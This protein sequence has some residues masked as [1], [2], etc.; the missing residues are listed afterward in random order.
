MK[1][2]KMYDGITYIRED[3]VEEA[4][5][6]KFKKKSTKSAWMK[7]GTMA[8]CACLIVG[9]G[10]QILFDNRGANSGGGGNE[11]GTIFMSYAG[12]VFPLNALNDATGIVAERNID[13]D[14]SPY[15]S[16]MASHEIYGE[17]TGY[18]YYNTESIV[19]DSYTLSNTSNGDIVLTA[20]YPFVGNFSSGYKYIP[21]ISVNGIEVETEL[22][23]GRF[24][25]SFYSASGP[26]SDKTDR[27]N[28]AS[29]EAWT[30]FQTLL[31]DGRYLEDA[32]A[33]YPELNQ[34]VIVYKLSNIA[35]NGTD[36]KATNPT[37]CLE[38]NATYPD[39]LILSYGSTGGRRDREAGE[40]QQSY[41]IPEEN[42]RNYGMDRYLI[43]L[44]ED[45]T[46]LEVKGYR[47]GG[48]DEG[49]DIEGVTADL[50]R[51]ETTLGEIVWEL[52][53]EGREPSYFDEEQVDIVSDEMLFGSV[54]ELMYDYGMLSDNVAERYAWG[55]LGDMWS[56]TYNMQRVMYVTF[57]V[58]VP[59]NGSVQVDAA[60]LKDAS[61]DFV[62]EGTDRN[63]YD[64]VTQLGSTLEFSSQSA[65]LSNSQFIEIVYQNF[66]FDLENGI[67]Q[68]EL[69]VNEPR[70]YM[71][72]RKVYA[73]G[74]ENVS[75]D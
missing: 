8:A 33:E 51:Y 53:I 73:E 3:I 75:V 29:A 41:P 43:I 26:N 22:Y 10:A 50:E 37:L 66:G 4:V 18:K 36:E 7:W 28:V 58:V 15:E 71:E 1:S 16:Q 62:G 14:F 47:D 70:Y 52:L 45:V 42:E 72:I 20:S 17:E 27:S 32:Y 5:D 40:I 48:C 44:G 34:N 67:T 55:S 56:E 46:N 61:F 13:F 64:M 6:Y 65:S 25:G 59:A 23:A 30:D 21:S 11:S 68:V 38:F 63:G 57:D 60:M 74:E 49:E 35:Y 12:P 31:E 19:T 54:A 9:V 2:E 24:S 69:D 39:T